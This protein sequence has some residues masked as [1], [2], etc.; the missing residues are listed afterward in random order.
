MLD[1][2]EHRGVGGAVIKDIKRRGRLSSSERENE[3]ARAIA[4]WADGDSVAAHVAY[5]NDVFCTEDKGKS[6]GGKSILDESNRCWL[7]ETYGVTFATIR[8]L[9]EQVA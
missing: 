5:K 4:E 8:E 7:Q 9:A 6:A 2:I 3:F 1:A